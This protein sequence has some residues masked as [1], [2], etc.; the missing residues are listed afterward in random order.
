MK[1]SML[2]SAATLRIWKHGLYSAEAKAE[3]RLVREFL[4]QAEAMLD[5]L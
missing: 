3:S 2:A 5:R 1:S 4:Q